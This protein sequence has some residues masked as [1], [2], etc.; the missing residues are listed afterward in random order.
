MWLTTDELNFVHA[1]DASISTETASSAETCSRVNMGRYQSMVAVVQMGKND[2]TTSNL[3]VRVQA[4]VSTLPTATTAI[5]L[6]GTTGAWSYRYA[7]SDA[8]SASTA[9]QNPVY[10]ARA[11]GVSTALA[12]SSGAGATYLIEVKS[13]DL[14]SG[15]PYLSISVS[16]A[17]AFRPCTV[18]YVLKPRYPQLDMMNTQ[19]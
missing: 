5:A 7:T 10:S 18:T 11:A 12:L 19:S 3:W 9:N 16:A 15:Y 14:P 17:L 2:I 1:S 8:V 6:G 4:S 13:D